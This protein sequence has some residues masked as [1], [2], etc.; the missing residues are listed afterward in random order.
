MV[1]MQRLLGH[2]NPANTAKYLSVESEDAFELA[3]KFPI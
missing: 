3:R 1:A 2:N